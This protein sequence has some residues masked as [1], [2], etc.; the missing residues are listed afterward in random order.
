MA[1]LRAALGFR[2][3]TGWA[4]LVAVARRSEQIEVLLR[5]RIELLPADGSVPRFVYHTAAELEGT[6][7]A[8]LVKRA[9]AGSR[10]TA[11]AALKEIIEML[12]RLDVTLEHAGIPTGSTPVPAALDRI[13]A[14]HPL[15]H[16][17]EGALFQKAVAEACE[18]CSLKIVTPREKDVFPRA[19]EACGSDAARFRESLDGLRKTV[20]PPW[21]AD[22]K[23]AT[24]A[25]LLALAS[26]S[27]SARRSGSRGSS[28]D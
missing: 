1:I 15:I 17:A 26:G 23:T 16:A 14:S 7:P 11:Q 6:E 21:G 10:K 12:R 22:Q 19:A 9:V 13:L 2:L 28:K 4:A 3:H 18:T 5:R 20:G 24:A 8:A 27:S 25:A